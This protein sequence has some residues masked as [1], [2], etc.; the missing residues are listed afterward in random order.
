MSNPDTKTI[1]LTY[2]EISTISCYILMTTKYREGEAEAWDRLATETE[3]D[4]SPK[5]PKAE[6]NARF[7]REESEKL[8]AIREKMEG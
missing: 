5:F 6:S 2:E 3:P 4:G 1:T 8:T 7:W